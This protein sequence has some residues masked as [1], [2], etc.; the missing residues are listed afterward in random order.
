LL[1]TKLFCDDNGKP[2][3]YVFLDVNN[4]FEQ[5][6][7][8]KKEKILGRRAT[9][10]IPGIEKDPA[11]WIGV[12]GRVAL[13]LQP[14]QFERYAEQ[15]NKWF[16]VSAYSPR[17][18]YFIT[19]FEEITQRKKT[20]ESLKRSEWIA[21][22][23]AEE[24][25]GLQVKLEE[26]AVKVEEY[27]TKMEQL[28]EERAEKLRD[29]ERLAAI[30]AT[31]GMVGHDIRNPLQAIVGDLYLIASDVA[32]MPEGEGKESIKESIV[33]I[34][35]SVEYINKIVQD[36]QDY[37][38]PLKPTVRKVDFEESCQ[39]VLLENVFPENIDIKYVVEDEAK[40][41][42]SDA[43]LLKRILSNLVSNAVQAMPDGGE[44]RYSGVA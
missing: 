28:A 10:V 8:L 44:T 25:E 21:R 27:A 34:K 13:S 4:R 2:V 38:K 9:S 24:L 1:I 12:Y 18:G 40:E 11:D 15:L 41:L 33:A 5:M 16:S 32:S 26:K 20:E 22:Q 37:A 7:G 30:G 14:V 29:A 42:A 17:K 36:L 6:T 35:N 19:I 31:A 23:R 39:E 3:D 43:A